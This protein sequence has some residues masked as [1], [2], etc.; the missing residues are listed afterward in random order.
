VF[1]GSKRIRK[2][3]T[4]AFESSANGGQSQLWEKDRKC[5]KIPKGGMVVDLVKA[6]SNIQHAGD[7]YC[8]EK[9]KALICAWNGE[10]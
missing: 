4:Q 1:K 6:R 8:P 5:G 10:S 7:K 2:K 3:T 9:S